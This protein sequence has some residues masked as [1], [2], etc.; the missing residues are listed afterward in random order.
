V[1]G[2]VHVAPY[3]PVARSLAPGLVQLP[4]NPVPLQGTRPSRRGAIY[5]EFNCTAIFWERP[6]P[7]VQQGR[8]QSCST[9]FNSAL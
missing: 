2:L 1:A 4:F 7:Q 5:S 6:F 3:N 8:D 9:T